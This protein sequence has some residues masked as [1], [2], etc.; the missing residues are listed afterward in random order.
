MQILQW[1]FWILSALL[2]A[3]VLTS[4]IRGPYK[5]YPFL[6][7]YSTVLLLTTVGEV[8]ALF[9][10]GYGATTSRYY[11]ISDSIKR[12]LLFCVVFGF[13]RRAAGDSPRSGMVQRLLILGAL[14][15][16]GV[17]FLVHRG[18]KIDFLMTNVGRDLSFLSAVLN[19]LLWS[20]LIRSRHR[21]RQ[22]LM[23]TG[24]LGVQFT[25]EAIGHSL[26]HL[27]R[28]TVTAGDIILVTSHVLCL[29]FWWEALRRKHARAAY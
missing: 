24:G 20:L 29:Y 12:F 8:A 26:R 1:F 28:S 9:G 27:S 14:T 23:V 15:V 25:G 5:K 10:T 17:S 22:L 13:V 4:L 11:W 19:L 21:D 16:T 6:T 2:Q 3:L 18:L 7:V